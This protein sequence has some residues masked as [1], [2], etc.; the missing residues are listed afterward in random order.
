VKQYKGYDAQVEYDADART[1]HG[2]VPNIRGAI[3]FDG[4]SVDE[5]E[6]AFHDSVDLYLEVCERKGI[7]PARPYSGN[8]VVRVDPV[9]HAQAAQAATRAGSSLNGYVAQAIEEHLSRERRTRSIAI[10]GAP[11]KPGQQATPER[12]AKRGAASKSGAKRA[13][14]AKP[15]A[16]AAKVAAKAPAAKKAAATPAAKKLAAAK[17]AAKKLTGANPLATRSVAGQRVL[18]LDT[19]ATPKQAG[20]RR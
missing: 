8:F 17:P 11:V 1:F 4:D 10:P 9:L 12:L 18:S 2:S 14:A 13:L 20:K 7:E 19:S 6:Q 15:S 5:L 3:T 16:Q